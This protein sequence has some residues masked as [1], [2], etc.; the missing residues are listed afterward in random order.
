MSFLK[1]AE[2]YEAHRIAA[3]SWSSLGRSIQIELALKE[4]RR[5]NC[6]D[7]L[8]VS[9]A[10]Y[11]RLL[12][13]SPG[14]D[15]D[16]IALF[17]KRFNASYPNVSKPIICNGLQLKLKICVLT[18]PQRLRSHAYSRTRLERSPST[19]MFTLSGF[20]SVTAASP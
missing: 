8:K 12:E 2:V 13:S 9:R 15:Q 18:R 20:R 7:F 14:I 6:R 11:D 17:N 16:I 3:V 5:K 19:V 1:Y 4:E 10:E